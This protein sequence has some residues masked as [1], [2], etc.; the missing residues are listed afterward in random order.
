MMKF[1]V[2]QKRTQGRPA[3][4]RAKAERCL[5]IACEELAKINK[6]TIEE[7]YNAICEKALPGVKPV[8]DKPAEY[9]IREATREEIIDD[10]SIQMLN[11]GKALTKAGKPD[12]KVLN[13][14]LKHFDIPVTA[15][16][17]N[18]SFERVSTD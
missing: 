18:D 6:T 2:L 10:A 12:L 4:S 17:R 8:E 3:N 13:E 15:A 1:I 11:A 5:M 9:S 7:A 16:E 14:R